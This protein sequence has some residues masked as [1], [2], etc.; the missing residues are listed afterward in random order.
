LLSLVVWLGAW[1]WPLIVLRGVV[2]ANGTSYFSDVS[3]YL[4]LRPGESYAR[5]G[6]C[7]LIGGLAG[8]LYLL[9]RYPFLSWVRLVCLVVTTMVGVAVVSIAACF[10]VSPFL[11]KGFLCCIAYIVFLDVMFF[12]QTFWEL[13]MDVRRARHWIGTWLPL[14]KTVWRKACRITLS[15]AGR[16]NRNE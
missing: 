2:T 13:V 14:V 4:T 16:P 1:H 9:P 15:M 6:W 10:A 7:W 3:L 11:S 12:P 5:L 8:W